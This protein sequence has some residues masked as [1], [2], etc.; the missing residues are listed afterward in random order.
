MGVLKMK[1]IT[2]MITILTLALIVLTVTPT[3]LAN[4]PTNIPEEKHEFRAAWASHLISSMPDYTTEAQFKARATEMLDI[5]EYYNFNA[6]IMHM[7]T[8]NNAYY[9]SELSPKAQKFANVDFNTF[10][11]ML[12]FIEATHARGMEFHAWLNPYRLGTSYVGTMPSENPASNPNN[13]LSFG[14]GSILNPGLPHVRA[15]VSDTIIEILDRYPVDAIHFDDYFYINLGANGATSGTN[16]IL[17]EP[18]Q[19]TFISY[20]DGFNTSSA[21]DKAN[22]RRHQVNLMIESVS[23]TI[24]T[25]NETNDR[26]VQFGISPTGIYKNG[27]GVVTYD[28]DG[29]PITTGS[30]TNGQTHFS[31]YLF[32]DS[33]KW[34]TEG[35]IDYL[36]PQSYWADSHPV[37]SYTKIMRWWNDVFKYLDVNL[38]SGIGVYMAD[39]GSNTYGWKTN[40]YE[41]KNQ[42]TYIESLEHVQGTSVYS[43][44]FVDSAYKGGSG[45]STTQMNHAKSNWQHI[46]VLPELRSMAP[47]NPGV[48]TNLSHT[49]GILS[50]GGL[51]NAKQYYIYRSN[52]ELSFSQSEI[53]GVIRS[54]SDIINYQTD[55]L[56]GTYQYGVRALSFTNTLGDP[57]QMTDLSVTDGAAIR[58]GVTETNQ[59]LRFYANIDLSLNPDEIGFYIVK[60]LSNLSELSD[61]VHETSSNT[62]TLNGQV[63]MKVSA[64]DL[65]SYGNFNVVVPDISP[66]NFS[67]LYTAVA[68]FIK[69][70]VINLSYNTTSRSVLE[71]AYKMYYA[72]E[73]TPQISQITQGVK[74]FGVDAFGSL[75]VT[76]QY[77]TNHF[78]LKDVFLNDWNQTFS[79]NLVDIT[80][81][82]FF[83]QAKIGKVSA[84]NSLSGSRLYQFFKHESMLLKWGWLLD[85][86][87]TIDSKIW[88]SRQIVA[89]RGDGTNPE[90]SNIYDGR[91][92]ITTL[93]GF[94]NGTH[95]YDGYP[96]NDF[97][98]R[99]MYSS[100]VDFNDQILAKPNNFKYFYVGDEVKLP[101]NNQTGFS[102]YIIDDVVFNPGDTYVISENTIIYSVFS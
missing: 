84:I 41:M 31:S 36:I 11:P 67:Q 77:E 72:N 64:T 76:D 71:V 65:D 95:A 100:L 61:V 75:S 15:F 55:D 37:A 17:N 68:Y 39:S 20:S 12:W 1:K 54:D 80:I 19:Q 25:F 48:V 2:I 94:F 93:I 53:V 16:T 9:V 34:A 60:G 73:A 52:D 63:V 3:L 44:N 6:L 5:L 81:E 7:R 28:A 26:H 10:D 90:H 91:H 40:P 59:A 51:E 98:S 86:I 79:S 66:D 38:Y 101:N 46:S 33:V 23:N 43:Y 8:H 13:I 29:K 96:T 88:P 4:T 69:D 58:V 92:L 30:E 45:Y 83:E 35:W 85:Y 97:T 87:E 56:N 21:A 70:D 14:G 57:A 78:N 89:L 22:W 102:H 50:F 27:D 49:D 18:D 62:F 24:Q 74:L 47:V 82:S 32:A 42:L 99:T